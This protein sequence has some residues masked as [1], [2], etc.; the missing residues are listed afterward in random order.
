MADQVAA[1]LSRLHELDSSTGSEFSLRLSQV[2]TT[3][4][5]IISLCSS[6]SFTS[7]RGLEPLCAQLSTNQQLYLP[8]VAV[9]VARLGQEGSTLSLLDD[10]ISDPVFSRNETFNEFNVFLMELVRTVLSVCLAGDAMIAPPSHHTH[11][12]LQPH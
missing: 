7:G 8:R 4:L 9:G 3:V 2:N 1:L 6:L 11:L 12:V 5:N 10:I